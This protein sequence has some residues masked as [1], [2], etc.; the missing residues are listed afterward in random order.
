M[1]CHGSFYLLQYHLHP[2]LRVKMYSV[3]MN[4]VILSEIQ[5]L[6]MFTYVIPIICDASVL[7]SE[8]NITL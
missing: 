1:L 5:P 6:T 2:K 7:L 4:K 8:H 3:S